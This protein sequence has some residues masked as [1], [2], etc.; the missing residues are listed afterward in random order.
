MIA[1][2]VG[3]LA[4]LGLRVA[5]PANRTTL[6]MAVADVNNL[7]AGSSV[8]L[9]GVPVGKVT[10][11]ETSVATANIHFYIADQYKIPVDSDVRLE[12][13]SALGESYIELEPRSSGGPI[14][15]D[16][17]RIQSDAVKQPPSITELATS[18][19]R[20]LNQL[21]PK[22]LGNVV[23]EADMALPDPA[24]VLPNL[25]RASLLIRNT[26]AGFKGQGREMLDN[27][28]VLLRNAGFVGPALAGAGP[29]VRD[30]GP[31][32]NII[33]NHALKDFVISYVPQNVTQLAD[34]VTRIQKFLDDRGTDLKVLGEA[35]SSNVVLIANAL[36][37]LDSSQILSN[38]LA[39]VPE[40]GSIELHV[41]VPR[42]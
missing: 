9:R 12:N 26:V 37:N 14:F 21:D 31:V 40:D 36:K 5:P 25:A 29:P 2:F 22:Q 28:Q 1:V 15:R 10:A 7:V 35:T 30:I 32:F 23:G 20:V 27:F 39:T 38:L 4:S 18:V 13:L 16:G 19:V 6:S 11:I 34:L 33:W 8:L 3:Y 17:Q 24:A 42:G 41:P